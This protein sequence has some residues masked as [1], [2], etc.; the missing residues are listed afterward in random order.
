VELGDVESDESTLELFG[1]MTSWLADRDPDPDP[2]EPLTPQWK[3]TRGA[4]A[5]S[6]Q[7]TSGLALPY[8]D[9]AG[10][11][12]ERLICESPGGLRGALI[13]RRDPLPHPP[14]RHYWSPSSG[15]A[16][17]LMVGLFESQLVPSK[18]SF[19]DDCYSRH[20]Q[21]QKTKNYLKKKNYQQ[22]TV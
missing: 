15:A 22:G 7:L 16:A 11:H 2:G 4:A 17:L 19:N 20:L 21:R 18:C 5:C 12:V 13:G 6:I 8:E 1:Q 9:A 14:H 10:G 3:K